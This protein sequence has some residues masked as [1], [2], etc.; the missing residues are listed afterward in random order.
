MLGNLKP[1]R[2]ILTLT[3]PLALVSDAKRDDLQDDSLY[4]PPCHADAAKPEDVYKFED[5]ILALET[6]LY[7]TSWDVCT[8]SSI[9][10]LSEGVSGP[11][12]LTESL[13]RPLQVPSAV[14]SQLGF[15]T[16]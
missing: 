2:L 9:A 6:L 10:R 11:M 1:N 3:F 14:P 13:S 5:R 7:F 12:M 8:K 16:S 15:L 4:L